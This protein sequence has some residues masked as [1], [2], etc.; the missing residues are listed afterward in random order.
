MHTETTDLTSLI[1]S[2]FAHLARARREAHDRAFREVEDRFES[3]R[4]VWLTRT[5]DGYGRRVE[6]TLLPLTWSFDESTG[7]VT[8]HAG[9]EYSDEQA[10]QVAADWARVFGMT[11]NAAAVE[12]TAEWNGTIGGIAVRVWAVADRT[13]LYG[14]QPVGGDR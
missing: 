12:G 7:T 10:V 6:R 4:Q 8:G 14:P 2:G 13:A 11:A 9:A 3:D 1:N 5:M